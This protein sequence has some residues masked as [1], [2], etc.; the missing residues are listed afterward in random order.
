MAT[1]L[2][3]SNTKLIASVYVWVYVCVIQLNQ[4]VLKVCENILNKL[5]NLKK[6]KTVFLLFLVE[7]HF[8]HIGQKMKKCYNHTED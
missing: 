3:S 2:I 8:I 6:N 4:P 7:Q 5:S 1:E